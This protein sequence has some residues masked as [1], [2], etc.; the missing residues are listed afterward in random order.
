[1]DIVYDKFS[2]KFPVT[3]EASRWKSL[4]DEMKY[5]MYCAS[6]ILTKWNAFRDRI[7]TNWNVFRNKILTK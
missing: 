1:M 2:V 5:E 3:L 7:L 6:S 4:N